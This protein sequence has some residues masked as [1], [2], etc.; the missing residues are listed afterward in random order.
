MIPLILRLKRKEHKEIA[1]AQD[2]IVEELFN[3]FD[4]AILRGGTA[5]WRCFSGN[6]FS[7]D[8]DVFI[9]KDQQKID[10]FFERLR[11]KGFE[12]E[13]K[14]ISENSIFSKLKMNTSLVKFEAIFKTVKG[15]L[16]EYLTVDSNILTVYSFTAE[17]FVNGKVD[18]YLNRLKIRDLYDIFFLLR[19]IKQ[20][21]LVK[22]Q[23]NKLI[24]EF[25]P[26]LDKNN[27]KVIIL[28]GICPT[29]E[30]MLTYIRR[31]L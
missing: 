2:L 5:I 15:V 23:L 6:R 26:P 8:I 20:K 22:D 24:K 13:K 27:L 25:K 7:E 14:K 28:E 31:G 12:I 9:P 17:Q 18:T 19:H 30:E 21:E 10:L 29:V 16:S 1:K 4:K 11:Q 3:V